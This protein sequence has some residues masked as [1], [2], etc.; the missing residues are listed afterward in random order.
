M[1]T[2]MIL[3]NLPES[4][5]A[6]GT[7]KRVL[8]STMEEKNVQMSQKARSLDLFPL[9]LL[10]ALLGNQNLDSLNLLTAL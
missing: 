1:K 2:E 9:S 7:N 10:P 3:L 4:P 5:K 8:P 6:K